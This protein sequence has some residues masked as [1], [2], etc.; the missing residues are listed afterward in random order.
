MISF[1]DEFIVTGDSVS[2][3]SEICQYKKPVRIYYD[4]NFCAPKHI[5]FCKQLISEG[6][7]FPFETLLKKCNKI[8]TLNT[9]KVISKEILNLMIK[10]KTFVQN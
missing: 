3:L 2:M 8:R 6:Y 5:F 10:W 9:A 4:K 7:A 1:A